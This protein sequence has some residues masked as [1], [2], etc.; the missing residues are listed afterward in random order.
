MSNRTNNY[1]WLGWLLAGAVVMSACSGARTI[2][3]G[4]TSEVVI[5]K[6]TVAAKTAI[7][8]GPKLTP[9]WRE[10]QPVAI[11]SD[12]MTYLNDGEITIFQGHVHVK[13]EGLELKAPYLKVSS[14]SGQALAKDGVQ[15]V[16]RIQDAVIKARELD[17]QHDLS[18][19]TARQDVH[20]ATKDDAGNAMKLSSDQLDWQPNSG[21]GRAQGQVVVHYKAV[22]ATAGIM[23]FSDQ[24]KKIVLKA[25]PQKV[26]EQP[27]VINEGDRI[28]GQQITLLMN[29][30]TYIVTGKAQ[31]LVNPNRE[32]K[33][34]GLK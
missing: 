33:E 21:N 32:D 7:A 15:L 26:L 10:D 18:H 4:P 31:A 17:Y 23:T 30:N 20:L 14:S 6:Q 11:T 34:K 29:D 25:D 9:G 27:L 12:K 1:K 13:Q 3:L 2:H 19:V 24:E 8:M 16:D 5:E 28:S 22:T